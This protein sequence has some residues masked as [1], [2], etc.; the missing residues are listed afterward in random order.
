MILRQKLDKPGYGYWDG[1]AKDTFD[2][3][4]SGPVL[5]DKQGKYVRIGSWDANHW[6]HVSV[7]KTE[8]MTLSYAKAHLKKITRVPC[9]FEY[10]EED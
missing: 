4:I 6:F 2:W 9:R 8:K 3:S 7:G 1:G 5:V 10:I